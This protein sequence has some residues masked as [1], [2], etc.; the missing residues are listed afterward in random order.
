MPRRPRAEAC[1]RITIREI[2]QRVSPGDRTVDLYGEVLG[3]EWWRCSGCWGGRGGLG[4]LLLCPSCG[5][6]CRVLHQP[7]ASEGWS[8]WS[9]RPVSPRSHRRPGAHRGRRKGRSWRL[10]QIREEQRRIVALLGLRDWPPPQPLWTRRDLDSIALL[11]TATRLSTRRRKALLDRLDA[12][13]TVKIDLIGAEIRRLQGDGSSDPPSSATEAALRVLQSTRGSLR[14]TSADSRT[15]R[16]DRAAAIDG[17]G[18]LA[19]P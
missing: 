18:D 12:L 6:R 9:C 11:P 10:D 17:A 15:L 2:R 3:L 8:C 5:A 4:L 14:R 16:C 13:E 7:P 19:N 1:R